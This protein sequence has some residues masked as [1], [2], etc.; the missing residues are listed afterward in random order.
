[1]L[2]NRCSFYHVWIPVL[3]GG[4]IYTLFRV[5]TLLVFKMYEFLQVDGF[6]DYVRSYT[7]LWEI[8]DFVKYSLPDGLWVY[9]FTYFVVSLWKFDESKGKEKYIFMIIP[10]L[11]GV[12]GEL[13]QLYFKSIGTFD[14]HDL[15]ISLLAYIAGYISVSQS[16]NKGETKYG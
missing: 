12:G 14:F 1:M 16:K 4:L 9:A 5:D 3:I 13:L 6:I 10:L 8:P 2:W 7:M 11:C 15:I